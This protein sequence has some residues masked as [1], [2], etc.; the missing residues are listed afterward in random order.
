MFLRLASFPF[1]ILFLVFPQA[2]LFRR[3]YEAAN[4]H[5]RSGNYSAAEEEFKIILGTAHL[6]LGKIYLAQGNYKASVAVLESARAGPLH[7]NEGLLD[8]AIAYFHTGEYA[9][10]RS[11]EHTSELQ[12]PC[13]LVCRLLLEKK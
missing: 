9:K 4:N 12:S 2:D 7:S 11:E 10:G 5:H 3:H 1:L 8:L 13:N 6:R